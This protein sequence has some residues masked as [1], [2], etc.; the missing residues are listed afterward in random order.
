MP[1]EYCETNLHLDIEI[2]NNGEPI[3]IQL[4]IQYWVTE[5]Q[6]FHQLYDGIELPSTN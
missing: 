3:L 6:Y 5:S 1:I 2:Y 4:P